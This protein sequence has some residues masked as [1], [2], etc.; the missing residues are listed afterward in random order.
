MVSLLVESGHR[1]RRPDVADY[2][3][4]SRKATYDQ[5]I[6]YLQHVAEELIENRRRHPSEKKDLLNAMLYNKDPQTGEGLSEN[7]IV[8][9]MITFLIAGMLVLTVKSAYRILC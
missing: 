5:N 6:K 8:N 2:F 9:N 7:A 4:R 3:F 1:S